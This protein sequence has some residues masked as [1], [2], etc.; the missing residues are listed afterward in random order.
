M[1]TAKV[2]IA[3]G[4]IALALSGIAPARAAGDY[5]A[6]TVAAMEHYERAIRLVENNGPFDS[7]D[8]CPVIKKVI[9]EL[10]SAIDGFHDAVSGDAMPSEDRR[11]VL[12][13]SGEAN[14]QRSFVFKAYY[15]FGCSS[16]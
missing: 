1:R 9:D 3:I 16:Y 2:T 10:T 5:Q 7:S 13:L 8:S 4:A 6:K 12:A 15:R 14:K 11:K